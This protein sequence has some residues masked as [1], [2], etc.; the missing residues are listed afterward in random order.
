VGVGL[1]SKMQ[2]TAVL[3]ETPPID[4][5]DDF[6]SADEC[7]HIINLGRSD[8]RSASIVSSHGD[9]VENNLRRTAAIGWVSTDQT[10]IVR[11]MVQPAASA[12]G[13]PARNCERIQVV[14][15]EVG[16]RYTPHLYTSRA[17]P[18]ER[19]LPSGWAAI[20]D[21]SVGPL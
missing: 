10:V 11:S 15:S 19:P 20:Q 21:R 16:G 13:V 18:F 8:M 5:I 3:C 2:Y 7:A 4:V 17:D 9:T 1:F 6:A 12:A 14:H